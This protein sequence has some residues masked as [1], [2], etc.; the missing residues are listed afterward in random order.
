MFASLQVEKELRLRFHYVF[1]ANPYPGAPK[2]TIHRIDAHTPF[3]VLGLPIIPIEV[4][5]G[6][7]PVLGFRIGELTYITDANYISPQEWAKVEGSRFLILNA[8]LQRP[9]D[10]HFSLQEA[11]AMA[12][13]I[14]AETTYFTHISHAMGRN[15]DVAPLI[16]QNM[17]LAY[18]GL[19][20]RFKV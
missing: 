20:F 15:A 9:H 17:Q 6:K 5:H 2:V 18:D 13:E 10:T 1:D 3:E 12:G 8:L 19:S 16:P 14:K 4:M 11:I 7:L